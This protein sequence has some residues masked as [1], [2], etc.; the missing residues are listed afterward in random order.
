MTNS[1]RCADRHKDGRTGPNSLVT[2]GNQKLHHQ[3]WKSDSKITLN[4]AN[5]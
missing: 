4:F 2:K 5:Q 1:E 3:D